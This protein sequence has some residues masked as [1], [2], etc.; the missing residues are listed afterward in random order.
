MALLTTQSPASQRSPSRPARTTRRPSAIR[1]GHFRIPSH[2]DL[3]QRRSQWLAH[4]LPDLTPEMIRKNQP[5]SPATALGHITIVRS[6]IRSSQPKPPKPKALATT[7]S[8]ASGRSALTPPLQVHLKR[9]HTSAPP[10]HSL[11]ALVPPDRTS[12]SLPADSIEQLSHYPPSELPTTI[13]Q[14]RLLPPSELRD[15]SMFSDL[16]GRF[17]ATAMDGGWVSV[18]ITIRLQAIYILLSD[19]CSHTLTLTLTLLFNSLPP[20]L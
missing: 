11:P 15:S 9:K 1:I 4:Q 14:T 10:G 12:Q 2:Q 5:H 20:R 19:F 13:L 6:G 17:P 3:L 18:H 16:T 8:Q 7:R